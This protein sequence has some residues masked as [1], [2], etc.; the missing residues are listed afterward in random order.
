MDGETGKDVFLRQL[1]AT[2]GYFALNGF[3]YRYGQNQFAMLLRA[4]KRQ[5]ACDACREFK[6]EIES[7]LQNHKLSEGFCVAI[8]LVVLHDDAKS[9]DEVQDFGQQLIAM[10]KETGRGG[11]AAWGLG[12]IQP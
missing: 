10:V 8:G 4:V 1:G 9:L 12:L 5:E 3:A 11:I 2:L 6:I 7:L